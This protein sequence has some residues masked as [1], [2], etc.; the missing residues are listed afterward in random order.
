[1]R[2]GFQLSS[3]V[4]SVGPCRDVAFGGKDKKEQSALALMKLLAALAILLLLTAQS[5]GEDL[6]ADGPH[7]EVSST[8]GR[9]VLDRPSVLT[10]ELRN[11]AS[12]ASEPELGM[13]KAK[14]YGIVAEI[15]CADDRIK[16]LSG[17]QVVGDLAPGM[18]RSVRFTASAEGMQK[19]ICPL[20]LHISFS[21]LSGIA[22]SGDESLPD[23]VFQYE[24][25]AQEMPLQFSVV[26]GPD[27]GLEEV[28]GVAV[29]G[30]DSELQLLF[31]NH[32]DEPAIGLRVEPHP[33]APF[34]IAEGESE[35]MQIDPDGTSAARIKVQTDENTTP[36]YYP[37]PC[38]IVFAESPSEDLAVLI[39]VQNDSPLYWLVP[40]AVLIV[41]SG[42]ILFA[43]RFLQT[44]KKLRRRWR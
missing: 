37:L 42:G 8:S 43:E 12:D 40:A 33:Q 34:R 39:S 3:P 9:L 13:Q 41:L 36:G 5:S 44:K 11:N 28:R 23:F 29:P 10:I 31:A 2:Y 25:I 17:P 16:V 26:R 21:R 20:E 14:A 18:S 38:K 15:S 22:V 24:D 27:V 1:M 7:L 35:P 32:G 4:I 30:K 6:Q 19:G